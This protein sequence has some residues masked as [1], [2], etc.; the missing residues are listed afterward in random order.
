M[1]ACSRC[2]RAQLLRAS[3]SPS[4]IFISAG[5]ECDASSRF[6][7]PERATPPALYCSFFSSAQIPVAISFI[8]ILYHPS[9]QPPAF[10]CSFSITQIP[11]AISFIG[12]YHTV[13]G[14]AAG[15]LKFTADILSGIFQGKITTCVPRPP[16]PGNLRLLR[17]PWHEQKHENSGTSEPNENENNR[18]AAGTTRPSPR[19][20]R[21]CR[22]PRGRR[23]CPSCAP[24]RLAPPPS[25]P[26]M[27]V[28]SSFFL[29]F[30]ECLVASRA[31]RL[32]T[33]L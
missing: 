16:S 7:P 19:S 27:C 4:S 11:V 21:G 15:S 9:V 24:T 2:R 23:S 17:L 30:R 5:L 3:A 22:C 18:P 14:T 33:S 13:P 10:C 26:P 20:T 12:I 8:G 25:S 28:D 31:P 32:S 1:R 29:P 6:S